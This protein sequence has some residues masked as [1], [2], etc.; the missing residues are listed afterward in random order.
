MFGGKE[1]WGDGVDAHTFRRPFAG[2]ELG[3]VENGGFGGGIGNDAAQRNVAGDAGDVDDA[4]PAASDHRRPEFLAGQEN[5]AHQIQIEVRLQVSECNTLEGEVGGDG[6]FGIVSA[7]GVDEDGG[8]AE[9]FFDG[10]ARCAEAAFL[11][12]VGGKKRRRRTAARGRRGT[13]S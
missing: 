5:A 7:D 11:S 4:A 12:C 3:E 2:Q 8:S 10:L 13:G 6:D 9:G 1:A